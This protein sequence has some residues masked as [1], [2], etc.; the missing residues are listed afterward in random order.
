[1]NNALSLFVTLVLCILFVVTALL[2]LADYVFVKTVL[3][4]LYGAVLLN[5][6]VLASKKKDANQKDLPNI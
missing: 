4:T 5:Y 3:F 6:I 1:M 2:D